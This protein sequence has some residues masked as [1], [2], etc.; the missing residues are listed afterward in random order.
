MGGPRL[1][2]VSRGLT[3]R[4]LL[5]LSVALV[6]LGTFAVLQNERARSETQ[7]SLDTSLQSMTFAS[8]AGEL[9]LIRGALGSADALG[10]TALKN[11]GT[12]EDCVEDLEDFVEQSGLFR[13]AGFADPSGQIICSSSEPPWAFAETDMFDALQDGEGPVILP[14]P[15]A[16]D[17]GRT[18]LVIATLVEKDD[19]TAGYMIFVLASFALDFVREYGQGHDPTNT[20]IYTGDGRLISAHP[21]DVDLEAV[22]PTAR[23]LGSFDYGSRQVMRAQD[24]QGNPRTYAVI[25]LIDG[26]LFVLGVWAPDDLPSSDQPPASTTLG[27][28]LMVW[29]VSLG[30]AYLGAHRLVIRHL[31]RLGRQ[32]R[33]FSDGNRDNL[34]KV[35]ENAPDEISELSRDL[36]HLAETLSRDEVQLETALGEKTLLLREVH[37]RVRNNL[38][39]IASIISIQMRQVDNS[40]ARDLLRGL[41]DRVMTLATVHQSLYKLDRVTELRAD[42]LLDDILRKMISIS[43]LPGSNIKVGTDL[44]P[45][46]LDPDQIVPLALLATEAMTN[47][48]KYVEAPVGAPARIDIRLYE[49]ETG[50]VCLD[51]TNTCGDAPDACE[52]ADRGGQIGL[53]LI[54]AF[55]SQLEAETEQG[56]VETEAGPSFRVSLRFLGRRTGDAGDASAA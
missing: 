6:P 34:P 52:D 23:N 33:Q 48:L 41:H 4:L 16:G 26:Q 5:M 8:I 1:G 7:R 37:H 18:P 35:L 20:I 21:S 50:E 43:I 54:D 36:R 14:G 56:R 30:V 44:Q 15:D 27:F 13:F 47:A 31:R 38:Q 24:A 17:G 10:S 11:A 46:T 45:V 22:L 2:H 9:A 40:G 12:P 49:T 25:P 28:A 51:V 32:M 3:V 42:T 55:S 29:L 53:H 39:L 19:E